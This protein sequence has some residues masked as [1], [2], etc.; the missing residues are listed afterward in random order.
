[1]ISYDTNILIYALEGN[2][3]FGKAAQN[4]IER[5]ER[6]GAVLSILAYQE[7]ITGLVLRGIDPTPLRS[8]LGELKN[9]KFVDVSKTI[10]DKAC[11]LTAQY[12]KKAF[13]YD[14]IHLATA[15][16]AGS[17]VFYTSDEQ[18]LSL[19]NPDLKIAALDK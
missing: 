5:G 4:I 12:N 6:E 13:G 8:I 16:T 14:A 18:L 11:E 19:R 1:M 10:V 7:L 9:T 15:I 3:T 2:P 17:P